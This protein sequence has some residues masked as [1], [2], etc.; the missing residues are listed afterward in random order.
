MQG[1]GNMDGDVSMKIRPVYVLLTC[2]TVEN[3]LAVSLDALHM[4]AQ[5]R[6]QLA[7]A[8]RPIRG[9]KLQWKYVDWIMNYCKSVGGM[10]PPLQ[11]AERDECYH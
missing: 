9:K 11:L 10:Q 1:N 8:R 2:H 4:F 6:L 7:H 5:L 3:G